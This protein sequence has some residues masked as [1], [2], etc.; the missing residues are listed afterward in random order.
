M[1]VSA[2]IEQ[3]FSSRVRPDAVVR[4]DHPDTSEYQEAENF[5]GI[6]WRLLDKEFLQNNSDALFAMTP[7][8][9]R[10]YL[11]AFLVSGILSTEPRPLFVDTIVSM[12]DRSPDMDQWDDFFLQR[13]ARLKVAEYQALM[14]WILALSE[15]ASGTLMK[16]SLNRS[17]DTLHLLS[18]DAIDLLGQK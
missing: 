2:N 9:F 12:L 8:A 13:W 1:T 17:F 16:D 4:P 14:Q 3:A 6:D 5:S 18:A 15:E 10:Y 7:E 11:P